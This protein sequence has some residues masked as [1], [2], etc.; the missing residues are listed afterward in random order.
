MLT[1]DLA[2]G[3]VIT[4]PA[5]GVQG[6]SLYTVDGACF[7]VTE[8]HHGVSSVQFEARAG[9][10]SDDAEHVEGGVLHP[11][12]G[13]D[14]GAVVRRGGVQIGRRDH[15]RQVRVESNET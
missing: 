13:H 3:D 7:K 2:N 8:G 14:D 15:Y 10:F 4:S 1:C 11:G 12:P 9:A 5:L 6:C